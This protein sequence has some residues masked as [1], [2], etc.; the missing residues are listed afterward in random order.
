MESDRIDTQTKE[1]LGRIYQSLNPAEL[2]RAI[3]K[4]LDALYRMYCAKTESGTVHPLKKQS[5][6]L[7]TKY[8]GQP[9]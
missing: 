2:K 1:E 7:V 4:K 8:V 5:P 9:S 3:T 6:R